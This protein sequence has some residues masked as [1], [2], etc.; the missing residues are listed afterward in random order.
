MAAYE[1]GGT[2]QAVARQF[3]LH[4]TTV[5]AIL[6]RQGVALRE[7]AMDDDLIRQAR[8]LYESGLSLAA[9]GERLGFDAETIARRLKKAGVRIRGAHELRGP[10]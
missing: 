7:H 5:T 8:V 4:R 9:V 3:K 1:A 2:I 6:E 10:R